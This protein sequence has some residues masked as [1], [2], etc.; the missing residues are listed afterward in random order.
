MPKQVYHI[1]KF[2]GGIN[3]SSDPRDIEDNELVEATNVSVSNQGRIIMSGDGKSPFATVNQ[4]KT[5]VSPTSSQD[6]QNLFNNNSNI[7]SGHGLFSFVHDFDFNNTDLTTDPITEPKEKPTEFICINDG[8]DIDVWTDNYE[9]SQYD[10]WKHQLISLGKIHEG[11]KP[12]Y[13]KAD[14]GFRVC[15][16]NFSEEKQNFLTNGAISSDATVAVI[17]DNNK[18]SFFEAGEYIKIDSEVM[19][20]KAVNNGTHTLTVERGRFGSKIENHDD[21]SEIFKINVPKIFAHIKRPMLKKAGANTT[22]NRWIQDIQVP[23]APK[24]GA[25]TV[26]RS[27]ILGSDTNTL[28][29]NSLYPDEPEKVNLGIAFSTVEDNAVLTLHEGEVLSSESTSLETVVVLTLADS[30]DPTTPVDVSSSTYNFSIGKFI[31]ISGATGNGTN[32][33]GVFEIVGF[34]SGTGEVKIAADIDSVGYTCTGDEQVLLEDEIIDDNLKQRYIMGMS[35]LYDGGGSTMQESN[36]TTGLAHASSLLG[37]DSTIPAI[38][39]WRTINATLNGNE[40]ALT[41]SSNNGYKFL[42]HGNIFSTA[43]SQYVFYENNTVTVDADSTYYV[44]GAVKFTQCIDVNVKIYVGIGPDQTSTSGYTSLTINQPANNTTNTDGAATGSGL[45]EFA[46]EVSTGSS[47]DTDVPVAIQVNAAANGVGEQVRI[48]SIDVRKKDAAPEIMSATNSIDLRDVKNV[49]KSYLSFLCNN[50]KTGIFNSE[51]VNNTWNERI[52]GFRI[53]MKQVDI[54]GGGVADE[55]VMLYDV[56]LKEGTYIMHAKDMDVEDLRL[57]DISGNLWNA[58][59]TADER[60]VVTNSLKG[61]SVKTVPLLTYESENGYKFDTNLAALYKTMAVVNR[62]VFIGNLK[63]GNKTFPD[64]MLK[65]DTDKFDIFPDDGTHFIDVATSDGE[66]II[67][68]ESIGDKLVQFKEKN[69]YLIKVNS[70]GEELIDTWTGAGIKNQCQI[71]KTSNGIFWVNADGIF[72]YDG[73]NIQNVS[74]NKFTINNWLTNEDFDKPVIVGYDRFS[75]KII[76]LT[77][78]V[79]GLEHGGYIY[80]INNFSITQHNNLFNWYP[81][82]NPTDDVIGNSET[83]L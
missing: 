15:D 52:E 35:F 26:F 45:V 22:I 60:A 66:S 77:T 16:G 10:A 50:S 83:E 28:T 43:T 30:D 75:N 19:K 56:N 46:G 39:G 40:A 36:I 13:Y 48:I 80:D 9:E 79:E 34:G 64:R 21:D 37:E 32:V 3:K 62:K 18:A 73:E 65:S 25:L 53:Y 23:E 69:A 12:V 49:A 70:E 38:S 61:D 72:Y 51:T 44:T 47:P 11:V 76:I 74:S 58:T 82:F 59:A 7:S 14:N 68:L 2:E 24:H 42:G 27:N 54:I 33:N 57:G 55:W 78:N 17:V 6:S 1:K 29:D 63:I 4:D 5:L 31:S 20:I 41:T 67:A 81:V 8:A 71:S